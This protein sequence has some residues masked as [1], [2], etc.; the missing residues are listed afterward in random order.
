M[1]PTH[2]DLQGGHDYLPLWANG[3]MLW[4]IDFSFSIKTTH[5]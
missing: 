5:Q 1:D 4:G 3:L 2:K